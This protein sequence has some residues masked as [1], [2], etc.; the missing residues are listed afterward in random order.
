MGTTSGG[1]TINPEAKNLETNHSID[2]SNILMKS[3]S[4]KSFFTSQQEEIATAALVKPS[5]TK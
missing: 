1:A 4:N 3:V 2:Q 5:A